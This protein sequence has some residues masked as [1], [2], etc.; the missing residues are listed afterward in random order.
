[1][2]ELCRTCVK[3]TTDSISKEIIRR[4][5]PLILKSVIESQYNFEDCFVLCVGIQQVQQIRMYK[6]NP[7][8]MGY[9][10]INNMNNNNI[11]T[12]QRLKLL[13]SMMRMLLVLY[14]N[15]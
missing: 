9:D 10:E 11:T 2:S 7:S 14:K 4:L 13:Y 8:W 6:T 1:M 3:L 15:D 12:P 5:L